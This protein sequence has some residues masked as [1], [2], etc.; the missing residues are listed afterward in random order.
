MNRSSRQTA[1]YPRLVRTAVLK[2]STALIS[3]VIAAGNPSVAQQVSST[4]VKTL[5]PQG[6]IK[7]T[8]TWNLATRA[9]DFI[10]IAGMRGIDPNTDRLIPDHEARIRQA[11]L[12]MKLIAESEG[13]SLQDAVRLVVFVTDMFRFRPVVNKVQAELWGDGPYPPRTIIEVQRL[14]QDD[15]VEVEGTFYAPVARTDDR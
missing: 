2:L 15:I 6:A 14:N 5:S 4:G 10:F 1:A 11:F 12:N 7:P 8:G 13:A 3:A 9:G